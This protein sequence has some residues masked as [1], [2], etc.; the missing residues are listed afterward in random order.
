MHKLLDEIPSRLQ[1]NGS[2]YD[3]GIKLLNSFNFTDTADHVKNVASQAMKLACDYGVDTH[4]AKVAGILHD[5]SVI[6]PNENRIEIAELLKID[7]F[8]EEKEFPM[9]IHQK[10]SKEFAKLYF[11][12]QE[13]DILD[14]ISCHTTLRSNPTKLD[15]IIFL[16]DKISWDQDG[17]PPYLDLIMKGLETSLELG[18]FNFINHLVVHRM[19]LKVVHPWLLEAHNDLLKNQHIKESVSI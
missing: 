8:D 3:N 1:I 13:N 10:L 2:I 17:K 14:A 7:L 4:K 5:I 16:A 9:I 18:T 12:I 19:N 6:I 11:G 15:M